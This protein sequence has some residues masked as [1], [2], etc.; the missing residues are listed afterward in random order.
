M[1]KY[2]GKKS[3]SLIIR[4]N[5]THMHTPG[6]TNDRICFKMSK[7]LVLPCFTNTSQSLSAIIPTPC[8]SVVA[9]QIKNKSKTVWDSF[10]A[11]CI[12]CSQ[13]IH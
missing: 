10:L 5:T 8:C 11:G 6:Y 1:V 4:L 2:L 9:L 13:G 3:I 7:I 12:L